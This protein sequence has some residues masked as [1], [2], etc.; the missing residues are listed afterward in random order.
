MLASGVKN[1]FASSKARYLIAGGWNTFFGYGV[2]VGLYNA[3]SPAVHVLIIG[4]IANVLS[5]SMSFLTYKLFVFRTKGGWLREYVR[6]YIVYGGASLLGILLLWLLVDG[7]GLKIW[8]AQAGVIVF[9]VVVSYT[10]HSRFTFRRVECKP[11][12]GA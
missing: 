8:L 6:T 9:T 7:C 3:L 2:G 4:A 12:A 10:G 1:I 5:I 11:E